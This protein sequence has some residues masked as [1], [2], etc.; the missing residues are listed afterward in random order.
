VVHAYGDELFT[1][2][3]HKTNNQ[4]VAEDLVQETFLSVYASF[5]SF[6]G[7]SK[8]K[9]WIF[10][11]LNNK[12]IDYYRKSAHHISNGMT[13]SEKDGYLMTEAL[14][15]ENNN[16]KTNGLEGAWKDEE[17]LLDNPEFN[18]VMDICLDDLSPSWK[19]AILWKYH[20][21]KEAK[22]ICQELKISP[23]NY[24]QILHRAKLLLR[25][26]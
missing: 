24:W 4:T 11:I 22:E 3:L 12:I 26:V 20:F 19:T 18:Q 6:K 21:Q 9:T 14:F 15:D 7:D 23:S 17:H 16:W 10:R 2:A 25:N 5:D 13:E 1:W 8:P